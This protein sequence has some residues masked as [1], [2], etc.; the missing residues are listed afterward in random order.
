V[1]YRTRPSRI[2]SFDP[3]TVL[4]DRFHVLVV[5]ARESSVRYHVWIACLVVEISTAIEIE[6]ARLRAENARLLRLL[7]L[8]P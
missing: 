8:T 5:R 1:I 2:G 3:D 6:L 7:R 4:G